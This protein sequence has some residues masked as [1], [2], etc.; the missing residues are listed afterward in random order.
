MWFVVPAEQ[1]NN[2]ISSCCYFYFFFSNIFVDGMSNWSV[3]RLSWTVAS[4]SQRKPGSKWWV[5]VKDTGSCSKFSQSSGLHHA[6]AIWM[7][8]FLWR[9]FRTCQ[10]GNLTLSPALTNSNNLR[11]QLEFNDNY[12]MYY[13][14]KF[15]SLED[16]F[17]M[18]RNSE[19][20]LKVFK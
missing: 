13:E 1:I 12:W 6:A 5:V 3:H 19:I 11:I 20:W 18:L 17:K 9:L 16:I 7:L 4:G 2:E 10:R 14:C 8:L 15:W